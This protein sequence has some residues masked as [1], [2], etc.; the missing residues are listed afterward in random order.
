MASVLTPPGHRRPQLGPMQTFGERALEDPDCKRKAAVVGV[1]DT[2]L[3]AITGKDYHIVQQEWRTQQI[4]FISKALAQST[5]FGGW[6]PDAV[7]D[8][9]THA[10]VRVVQPGEV[11]VEQG[12]QIEE[13]FVVASGQCKAVRRL[14]IET[15]VV[16]SLEVR[17][18][19][20]A[21]VAGGSGGGRRG[22]G[23][24]GW[25]ADNVDGWLPPCTWSHAALH[26]SRTVCVLTL[27]QT[28]GGRLAVEA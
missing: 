13:V 18:A 2:W 21:A 22:A 5:V 7:S 27:S 24:N 25:A 4:R 3:L 20:G 12:A 19:C 9:S 16:R 26:F 17:E 14:G 23:G 11:L 8:L 1:E 28:G 6:S 15:E 10:T